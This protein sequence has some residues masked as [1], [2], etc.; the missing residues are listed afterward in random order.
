[1][2]GTRI[3]V[4]LDC[5]PGHDDAVAM[6]LACGLPWFHLIGVSTVHGNTSLD[7]TTANALS[8]LTALQA[9]SVN[10]YPGAEKPLVRP[11]R[12]AADIHGTS[13][14]DGTALL[15]APAYESQPDHT[16][17]AAMAEAIM[18]NPGSIS[19]IATGTLTNIALL[20]HNY[21]DLLPQ[22]RHLSIMGGGVGIGNTTPYAEFNIWCDAKAADIV[23]S[24]EVLSP[25]TIVVPL[26]LTH[27]AIAT[28]RILEMVQKSATLDRRSVLR[29]MYYEL[30]IFFADTYKKHQGFTAGPPVH[31]PLAVTVLLSLYKDEFGIDEFPELHLKYSRHKIAVVQDGQKEGMFQLSADPENGTL[32]AED[33]DLAKF[34]DLVLLALDN[35]EAHVESSL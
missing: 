12:V 23:L 22:I 21:P 15:P 28:E 20:V 34:W 11:L 26:N 3:P 32:I 18:A 8:I 4:W 35:I 16:A 29:Q 7:N 19:I 30:L 24:N 1:M 2:S 6:L 14:L 10:V 17:V 27:K 13:G 5:D 9:Y 33:I 31:D 25:R